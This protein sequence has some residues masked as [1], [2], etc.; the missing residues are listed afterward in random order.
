MYNNN[1]NN[2]KSILPPTESPKTAVLEMK[3]WRHKDQ[4]KYAAVRV[5]LW[6][7][8]GEGFHL[9]KT[10]NVDNVDNNFNN[11]DNNCTFPLFVGQLSNQKVDVVI[12]FMSSN[13]QRNTTYLTTTTTTTT[14]AA[15]IFIGINNS[16]RN[17]KTNRPN[18]CTLNR[19]CDDSATDYINV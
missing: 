13:I 19:G 12:T 7:G 15:V 4:A 1:N 5:K 2:N 10:N 8:T 3:V 17:N 14:A 6:Q 16:S 18:S 9:R 11:V